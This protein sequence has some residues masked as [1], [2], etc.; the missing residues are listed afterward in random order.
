MEQRQHVEQIEGGSGQA[1]PEPEYL[2]I[3]EATQ[4]LGVSR[5]TLFRWT[6]AG[7]P[8]TGRRQ[9]RR[10]EWRAIQRFLEVTG[11]TLV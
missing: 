6:R 5:M 8:S 3:V 1:D 2:T 9:A 11:R 7:L 10:Y 4:R